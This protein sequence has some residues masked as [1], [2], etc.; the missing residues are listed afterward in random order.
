MLLLL[1]YCC[2]GI[3]QEHL[4]ISPLQL[5]LL[6]SLSHLYS[7][8]LPPLVCHLSALP[9]TSLILLITPQEEYKYSSNQSSWNRRVDVENGETVV[10]HSH[11]SAMHY[12]SSSSTQLPEDME[13][14]SLYPKDVMRG[15]HDL[16]KVEPG[17]CTL[18]VCVPVRCHMTYMWYHVTYVYFLF[19]MLNVPFCVSK[20]ESAL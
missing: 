9:S 10:L 4:Y 5:L 12:P 15:F 17:L 1:C 8:P 19:A 7:S 6:L 2:Y 20:T 14:T 16:D 13:D 11:S 18:W 3:E